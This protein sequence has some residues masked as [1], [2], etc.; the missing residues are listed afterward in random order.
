[1]IPPNSSAE[2]RQISRVALGDLIQGSASRYGSRLAVADGE[3]RVTHHELDT[4]SSQFAHHLLT[5][6]RGAHVATLCANSVDMLVAIYG[7]NK[8]G[9]VWVPVN[10]QLAPA[11]IGYILQH[12][13]VS[14]LVIDE[15]VLARPEIAEMLLSL[16]IPLMISRSTATTSDRLTMEAATRGHPGEL[17]DVEIAG[18]QL[19]L[20]MYTSGT[21]GDPKGVMHSHASVYIAVL[22]NVATLAITESDVMSA[23]LPLFHCAQHVLATSALAAGASIVLTRGFDP[24]AAL[25][26]VGSDHVT[27]FGGLPMMYAAMLD[28]PQAPGTDFSAVRLCLYAMAPMPRVLI[29]RIANTVDAEVW[30]VTGQTEAYPITMRFLPME[31]PTLDANYW[32]VSTIVCET[33]IMDDRGRLLP[34]GE[35]GEIVHRGPNIM[36]GYFKDPAATAA[37]QVHGWHHTGDLGKIDGHGQLLFLDRK[38]DMIKTGGENVPSVK[39]E[40]ALLS[41]P[42][43][44][45]AAAIGVPHPHSDEAIVAVVVRGRGQECSV[46]D[47]LDHCRQHLGS[48]EVPKDVV[49]VERLPHTATGKVLKT[50][51]RRNHESHFAGVPASSTPLREHA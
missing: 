20:I 12:A 32:G 43:I 40:S 16:D 26:F 22:G 36:L 48:F 14:Y 31:H 45:D 4:P 28:H 35:I 18:D 33:E 19:A 47:V 37:A 39:V 23:M 41:H 1:M 2:F 38:K 17:P 44:A 11:Q 24:S 21:T 6:D 42:A 27:I 13:E 10:I 9:L 7:I 51:L 29:D 8:A 25:H 46:E 3:H 49:F 50:V 15:D 30:L 34:S 5:E